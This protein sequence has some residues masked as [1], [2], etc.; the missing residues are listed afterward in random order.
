[1]R[2]AL[3]L[4][5]AAS[6]ALADVGFRQGNSPQSSFV[7]V[8]ELEC[9]RDAG[10]TCVRD[11]GYS[12]GLLRCVSANTTEP[13]CVTPSD[14][15]WEGKKTFN[16]RAR[17][18]C[19]NHGSLTACSSGEKGTWQT[20]CTHNAPV[21]CDGTS[22]IETL[23]SQSDEAVLGALYVHGI[24]ATVVFGG[25]TLPSTASWT[26]NALSAQWVAGAGTGTLRLTILGTAGDCLCDIDCDAPLGRSTCAGS[27][28][29]SA[30]DTIIFTRSPGSSGTVACTL[31]PHVIGNL[32]VM[33]V[34]Q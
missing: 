19:K 22:N 20:C 1:M 16:N 6:I 17:I 7:P 8:R 29:Y 31:D 12:I 18:V 34:A 13:G 2:T 9:A 14:Q 23:G 25:F 3:L 28:T 27:C 32:N 21:F 33:G 5:F 26:I 15:T 24:P 10:L 4:S 11:A 30:S